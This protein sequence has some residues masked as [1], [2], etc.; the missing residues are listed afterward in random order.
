[1]DVIS[2]V[3]T[4]QSTIVV[5]ATIMGI[6]GSGRMRRT[7]LI[8]DCQVKVAM[9]EENSKNAIAGSTHQQD[10]PYLCFVLT[11]SARCVEMT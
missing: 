2:H 7:A 1:M 10:E 8:P 5:V 11:G 3:R 4:C 6:G 9:A